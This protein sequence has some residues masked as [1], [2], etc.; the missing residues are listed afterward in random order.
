[1]FLGLSGPEQLLE[2]L[3]QHSRMYSSSKH[4]DYNHVGIQQE[5]TILSRI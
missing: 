5:Q 3:V 1:M 2:L 4:V